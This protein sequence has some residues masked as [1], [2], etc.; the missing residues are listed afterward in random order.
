KKS[1]GLTGQFIIYIDFILYLWSLF[2]QLQH[3]PLGHLLSSLQW[4]ECRELGGYK[5]SKDNQGGLRSLGLPRTPLGKKVSDLEKLIVL[6]SA[7][8]WAEEDNGSDHRP[9]SVENE[10]KISTASTAV[11][12]ED[13]DAILSTNQ[14]HLFKIPSS[15]NLLR[16]G[17]L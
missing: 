4:R 16:R 13:D 14:D 12:R 2:A 6:T 1:A 10:G 3:P 8:T 7:E 15:T 17:D 9:L 5:M 11:E